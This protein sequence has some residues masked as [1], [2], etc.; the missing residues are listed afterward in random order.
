MLQRSADLECSWA[1]YVIRVRVSPSAV[2]SR[3]R[4]APRR[5]R[6]LPG[7]PCKASHQS[8]LHKPPDQSP[9]FRKTHK[10]LEHEE[11]GATLRGVLPP[12]QHAD[13]CREHLHPARPAQ[14]SPSWAPPP[15]LPPASPSAPQVS[16]P[17]H[18]C[19]PSS[20]FPPGHLAALLALTRFS[21]GPSAHSAASPSSPYHKPF[22]GACEP[23]WSSVF[24]L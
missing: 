8:K 4:K 17:Q 19:S 11:E 9:K 13:H 15:A 14:S 3:G 10:S 1:N 20:W 22:T 24:S 23:P 18:H 6:S 12:P 16:S 5:L 21:Q 2:Q 7:T